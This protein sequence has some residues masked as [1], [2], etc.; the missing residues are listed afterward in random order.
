MRLTLWVMAQIGLIW[1]LNTFFKKIAMKLI[2]MG[3]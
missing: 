1:R 3:Q 2:A